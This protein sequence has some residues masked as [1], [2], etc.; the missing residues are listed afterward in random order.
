MSGIRRLLILSGAVV[1]VL[2]PSGCGG[3]DDRLSKTEYEE[4]VRSLYA[5]V[6][7]AFQATN[8]GKTQLAARVEAAQ[9]ELRSAADE[10]ADVQPPEEVEAENQQIVQGMRAYA[11]D[12]E[13]LRK[14]AARGDTRTVED[15][16]SRIA[17]NESVE[18]IAEAAERMKFK[19]Y[20]LGPIAEE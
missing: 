8:V 10:L 12:L 5:D 14:A 19:G 7:A 20:N 6:Q 15:F 4:K 2:L 13:R 17:K 1:A 11:D 16:N 9:R 18:Q 3:G